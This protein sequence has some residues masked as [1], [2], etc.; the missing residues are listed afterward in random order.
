M[1]TKTNKGG[2]LVIRKEEVM[3]NLNFRV[4]VVFLLLSPNT[5]VHLHLLSRLSFCL[6]DPGFVDFLRN[7]TAGDILIDQVATMEQILVREP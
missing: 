7:C 2:S 4:F 3:R 6:R 1:I 5:K